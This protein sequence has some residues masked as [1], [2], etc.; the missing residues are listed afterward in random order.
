M[1]IPSRDRWELLTRHGL[2]AA[3]SQETIDVEVVVV[4]DGSRDGTAE[5]V[6]ALGDSR[7]RVIRHERS[8]GQAAARNAGVA[9]AQTS[10]VAF[11]DDDDVWSPRKLRTQVDAAE[12]SGADFAWCA[13][14]VVDPALTVLEIVPAPAAE[15]LAATLLARNVLR[16]GSSTVLA[17]TARVRD[18]GGFDPQLN[19][20]A[21]W[22]L[23]IRLA[24]DGAG[25]A[26]EEALVAYLL[27]PG[28]R[29]IVD[30][31]DVLA[32]Y[33]HLQ[34]KHGETASRLGVVNGPLHFSR[35]L[36]MGHARRGERL[37]AVREYVRSGVRH[38]SPS[39]LVR[40]GAALAGEPAF[41]VRRRLRA[42]PPELDWLA[43]YR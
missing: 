4:D 23:W 34:A 10:W 9:E 35:W 14:A 17:R 15:G 25:A 3:L 36:A 19:E 42:R 7:V 43:A 21:D 5:R 30:D 39:N 24:L 6:A 38:R 11:L 2:R 31:S 22:D 40:A 33:R 20:L 29:R 8:L 16:A 27:H 32:E 12:R 37:R 41:A 18:A 1:V 28:N 13:L 26:C